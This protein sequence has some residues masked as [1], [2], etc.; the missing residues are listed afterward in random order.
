MRLQNALLT[1]LVTVGFLTS[2]CCGGAQAKVGR[3]HELSSPVDWAVVAKIREEGLQRSHLAETLS[4]MTDVLGARLTLSE[5]MTR[6]QAIEV[7]ADISEIDERFVR[8]Q[9]LIA[10]T[11]GKYLT[12]I[13]AIKV[14][15]QNGT[16]DDA[17][18]EAMK[19]WVEKADQLN[20]DF[21]IFELSQEDIDALREGLAE[22]RFTAREAYARA[23]KI[24][25][26]LFA[27]LLHE[28]DL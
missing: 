8:F 19:V 21:S 15:V 7:M 11:G 3:T 23:K 22:G 26:R 20:K 10:E 14:L 2:P 24:S 18:I 4:F 1:T 13:K 5:G 27:G 25:R 28:F 6:A 9:E 12:S 17:A 16:D